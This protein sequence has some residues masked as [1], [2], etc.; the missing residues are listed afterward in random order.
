MRE[1]LAVLLGYLLGSVPAAYLAGRLTRGV[2]IR[3]IGG[4]NMGALNTARE[5]GPVIGLIVL[6]VDIA[7]GAGAVLASKSLGVAPVWV[8]AAGFAAILGHCWPVFL[9][10]R[11]GKGAAASLGVFFALAPAAFACCVPLIVGV[12]YLTSNVTLGIAIG[13]LFFP[14]FLWVFGLPFEIYMFVI[15]VGIFLMIR[16]LPTARRSL[17][18][19]SGAR[20][21]LIEKNYKPWQTRRK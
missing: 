12:I 21:F 19:A 8:Y 7:K 5:I 10:F 6:L 3:K 9:K 17:E 20:D 18:K 16:Y 15:A 11:G 2:D 13:I 14:L 1:A 4:G